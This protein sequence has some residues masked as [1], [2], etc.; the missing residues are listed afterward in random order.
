[1]PANSSV[2]LL[3]ILYKAVR[4]VTP[5]FLKIIRS[6]TKWRLFM[7]SQPRSEKSLLMELATSKEG[8]IAAGAIAGMIAHLALRAFPSAI[9]DPSW[10]LLTVLIFGGI[11]LIWELLLKAF[12]LQFGSDLLAGISIVTSLFLGEYLAGCLVVLM[13]SGGEALEEY[14]VVHASQALRVLAARLPHTAHRRNAEGVIEDIPIAEISIGDTLIVTP[15]DVCPVDGVVLEGNGVMDES[16]LTGEPFQLSKIPGSAVISGAVNGDYA[17]AIKATQRPEDSRYAK[18]MQVMK[19]AELEQPT[20]RR[21]GDLVGAWYTPIAVAIAI[22]AWWYHKSAYYFLA[23]LVTATPC[24]LLIA[25]PV[26]LIGSI[27]LAA[28]RGIIIRRPAVLELGDSCSTMVLDKTGTLTYGIPTLTD[29]TVGNAFSEKKVLQL[30]ASIEQY[31]RH[32][33]AQA[34]LRGASERGLPLMSASHISETPGIGMRGNIDGKELF[35]SGRTQTVLAYPDL[36]TQ[37]PATEDGLESIITIDGKFAARLTFRDKPRGDG[38]RF[39]DH[40][41]KKHHFK[42]VLL[43]SGDRE[44]EVRYLADLVGITDVH[45]S[46]A[47]EDKLK[48]VRNLKTTETVVFVGDGIN[49]APALTAAHVGIAFGQ[50]TDVTS[51]AADVVIMDPALYKVDEYLH[52]SHRLRSIVWQSAGGGMALSMFGVIIAA[53]GYL[54]PVGGALLQEFIDVVVIVNA[55]RA[56]FPPKSLVDYDAE[57][58]RG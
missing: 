49:D 17:L 19:A 43:V 15:H 31:S 42:N 35:I 47:P 40:L 23:V 14:A 24:P 30:A 48:I 11:P 28:R 38:M 46:Q 3:W 39:V 45:A 44:S 21:V 51:E 6:L 18:I 55:L 7:T 16:Y 50:E 41:R 9:V 1:M 27:S 57:I 8:I 36:S 54:P 20:M 25:I 12:R 34:I 26:A 4:P 58:E 10:P 32:P 52:L 2:W 13:L 56:A 37:L 29:V 5:L 33:L 22:F 53:A